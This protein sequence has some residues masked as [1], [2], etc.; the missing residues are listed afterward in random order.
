MVIPLRS[1]S[2]CCKHNTVKV[3]MF[4]LIQL[5]WIKLCHMAVLCS[6]IVYVEPRC[7]LLS[8]FLKERRGLIWL[9]REVVGSL[10]RSEKN[11]AVA[12]VAEIVHVALET[13]ISPGV[14]GDIWKTRLGKDISIFQE[15][16]CT[17]CFW[18]VQK[19][20]CPFV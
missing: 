20:V 13:I 9:P 19:L 8:C 17:N 11:R 14:L 5:A 15:G 7:R 4:L 18:L 2:A 10:R 3:G 16:C 1:Y 12:D 6:K